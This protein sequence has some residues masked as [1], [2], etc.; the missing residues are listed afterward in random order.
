M[1]PRLAFVGT[2]LL[3]GGL[4]QA[5]SA[6]FAAW[7][8]RAVAPDPAFHEA[9]LPEPGGS[10]AVLDVTAWA[11][12]KPV[13]FTNT[14]VVRVELDAEAL[15]HAA[16]DLRDV[17]VMQGGRQLPYLIER[18]RPL[19]E[20]AVNFTPEPDPKRPALSRW[21][22]ELPF[23]EYPVTQLM[24]E[25]SSP[26]FERRVRAWEDTR[27]A[28]A[29]SY[30]RIVGEAFWRR[31]PGMSNGTLVIPV[32]SRVTGDAVYL[33]TDN[34]DNPAVQIHAMRVAYAPASVVFMVGSDSPVHLV[35]GNPR[36]STPRYDIQLVR[37]QFEKAR[38]A[39]GTLGA[40]ERTAGDQK[41][42]RGTRDAGSAW[43]WVALALVVGGLL[44]IMA[45][46]LPADA[47]SR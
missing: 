45:K 16:P 25:S 14:G 39:D 33:E 4:L 23:E 40:E 27:D 38:K 43:L 12:R 9:K 30:R 32:T 5:Q 2:L 47:E 20:A 7:T 19:R 46:A 11:F 21:R 3:T 1:K 6:P 29:N 24:V 22:V 15:A 35:Y 36:A 26:L 28:Y 8:H 31:S 17:R 13:S 41:P 34:G 10:G 18:N 42:D 44:W 37:S